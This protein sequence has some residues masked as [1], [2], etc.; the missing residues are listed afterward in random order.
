VI[1]TEAQNDLRRLAC[2]ATRIPVRV[3]PKLYVTE[4]LK[5]ENYWETKL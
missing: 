4:Q 3:D 2:I 5:K 1:R